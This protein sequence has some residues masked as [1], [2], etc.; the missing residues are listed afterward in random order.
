MA[1]KDSTVRMENNDSTVRVSPDSTVK[2]SQTG[3]VVAPQDSTL[4][5]PQDSTFKMPQDSTLKAPQDSTLKMA[6]DMAPNLQNTVRQVATVAGAADYF[7]SGR[8]VEFGGQNY[9]IVSTISVDSGEAIVYRVKKGNADL[10][11]KHYKPTSVPNLEVLERVRNAKNPHV[12]AVES[13]GQ[14][15]GRY[16]E[17]ME[18][19]QGGSMSGLLGKGGFR[20]LDALKK[21]ALQIADGLRYLHEEL[22]I[23]YQDLKPNN[24]LFKDAA[25]TEIVIADFGISSVLPKGERV[26]N[27]VLSGTPVYAAPEL[28]VGVGEKYA[29]GGFEVD[30][31]AL[32]ITLWHLWIGKLPPRERYRPIELPKDM[33]ETLTRLINGLLFTEQDKPVQDRRFTHV[34]VAQWARGEAFRQSQSTDR[35]KIV[36]AK[37]NFDVRE[38]YSSPKELAS[39]LEKNPDRGRDYLFMGPIDKWLSDSNDVALHMDLMKLIGDDRYKANRRA[40]LDKARYLLDP[41]RLF[42]SEAGTTCETVEEIGEAMEKE[43]SRYLEVIADPLN[44]VFTYI[45]AVDGQEAAD[46]FRDIVANPAYTRKRAFNK[47]VLLLQSNGTGSI[48]LLGKQFDTLENLSSCDD[49]AI[50][51]ELAKQLSEE[52]SKLLV[53]LYE[54]DVIGDTEGISSTGAVDAFS[55]L[56]AFSWLDYKKVF[57]VDWEDRQ[58]FDACQLIEYRRFDLLTTFKNRGLSFDGICLDGKY[59][60]LTP[61]TFAVSANMGDMVAKLVELGASLEFRDQSNNTPLYAAVLARNVEMTEQLLSL[62]AVIDEPNSSFSSLIYALA[63]YD[64][65]TDESRARGV[66]IASMLVDHGAKLDV[67]HVNNW[68]PLHYLCR[69]TLGDDESTDL[70]IKMLKKGANANALAQTRLNP[71]RMLFSTPESPAMLKMCAALLS[72]GADPNQ[73]DD[74]GLYSPMIAAAVKGYDDCIRLM[75]K[76]GGKRT[77]GNCEGKTPY[78]YAKEEG[79]TGAAKL[80]DPGRTLLAQRILATGASGF[81]T[82]F[83]VFYFFFT[84]EPLSPAINALSLG[85]IPLGIL[86]YLISLSAMSWV[87][88]VLSGSFRKFAKNFLGTFNNLEGVLMY[89]VV[90]PLVLPLCVTLVRKGLG[91]IPHFSIVEGILGAPL[92]FLLTVLPPAL[93][94]PGFVLALAAAAAP[95]ILVD[96]WK[97]AAKRVH[98]RY[99]K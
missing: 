97:D 15:E 41:D 13:F 53:W 64:E 92:S 98:L 57:S 70:L 77:L 68:T 11:L 31:F 75:L 96:P 20:D 26:G 33:D 44:P 74:D 42:V 72:H 63:R 25:K 4:K 66:K 46:R 9:T 59:D 45:E 76:H 90:G 37:Y 18:Y 6:Q 89:L 91:F 47:I 49:Q 24:I 5:A 60:E 39:L 80:L 7:E 14:K 16:Y 79:K 71:L 32:G 12:V 69:N 52:D 85:P 84:F 95:V 51:D 48:R 19:A 22:G 35:T 1:K 17:I 78:A 2:V 62:G 99:K 43:A 30:F 34:E 36:Y 10:V 23:V 73:F 61:L 88:L 8:V 81:L 82:A 27:L 83:A 56:T 40:A 55:L 58:Y 50:R 93:A 28:S 86:S 29:K 38:T 67:H 94:L 21:Y 65:D 87:F 3:T 54:R